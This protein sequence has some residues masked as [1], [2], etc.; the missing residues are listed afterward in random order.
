MWLGDS[1][2]SW[3]CCW[4]CALPSACLHP[5]PFN[6]VPFPIYPPG[7]FEALRWAPASAPCCSASC[8]EAQRAP[9]SAIPAP[10]VLGRLCPRAKLTSN[11]PQLS[12]ASWHGEPR[13]ARCQLWH[14][15]GLRNNPTTPGSFDIIYLS[16]SFFLLLSLHRHKLQSWLKKNMDKNSAAFATG[17][18]IKYRFISICLH[19]AGYAGLIRN[20]GG[21]QTRNEGG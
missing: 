18:S 14:S 1:P 21:G 11:Q 6:P 13:Q 17:Y 15:L 16:W 8:R 3:R 2:G 10:A 9:S 19:P 4:S 7:Q 5:Q 12:S 20:T